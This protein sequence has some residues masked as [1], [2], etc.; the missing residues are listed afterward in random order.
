[1]ANITNPTD[2]QAVTKAGLRMLDAKKLEPL[3]GQVQVDVISLSSKG[4]V[5]A[6]KSPFINGSHVLMDIYNIRPK[7]AQVSFEAQETD[8]KNEPVFLA[9]IESYLRLETK[10]GPIFHLALSWKD[11]SIHGSAR[12]RYLKRLIPKL[13]RQARLEEKK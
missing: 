4:C 6:M 7:T 1:M 2:Q 9:A 10:K 11:G 13:K 8:S 5:L 12:H 3:T